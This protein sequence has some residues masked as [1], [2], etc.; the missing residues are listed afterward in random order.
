LNIFVIGEFLIGFTGA[1][2]KIQGKYGEL[3]ALLVDWAGTIVIFLFK[4][5]AALQEVLIKLGKF[6]EFSECGWHSQSS[7]WETF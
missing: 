6:D 2:N 7:I 5:I 1:G 3:S 4:N